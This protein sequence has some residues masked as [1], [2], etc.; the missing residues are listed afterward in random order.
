M[1]DKSRN[2][3]VDWWNIK[4]STIYGIAALVLFLALTAGGIWWAIKNGDSI[5]KPENADLPKDAAR[6]LSF[7]GE[8][9]VMR[10]ATR[11]TILVTKETYLSAGDTVQTQAD[12]KAQIKMIDG[13]MLSVRPNSTVV[14]RDSSSIFGGTNVRVALDDG[15]IN[16]RTQDQTDETQN[17]VEMQESENRLYSQTDASFNINEQNNG[18]EIRISRGSVD[19]TAGGEKTTLNENEFAKVSGGKLTA[20]EK[21]LAPPTLASPSQNAQIVASGNGSA[22][23]SFRWEKSDASAASSFQLQI[24]KS[25]FFVPDAMLLM[26]ESLNSPTFSLANLTPGTYYWRVRVNSTS[27][28]STDWSEPWR[29]SVVKAGANSALS[30]SDWQVESVGSNVYFVSGKTQPGNI[31]RILGRETFAAGDGNFRLQISS[32]AA[33]ATIEIADERGNRNRYLLSLKT[34]KVIREG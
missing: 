2:Y 21:L 20:K 27:G 25:P 24:A 6:L 1:A 15:Q 29:F 3:Y 17:V 10:A 9:R 12:G 5:A 32:S 13:S 31:V 19:S 16:V 8:V 11:E 22:D 7:E 30:A 26:R 34:G 23:A 4:R 18:G 28:Q 14:I 33:E